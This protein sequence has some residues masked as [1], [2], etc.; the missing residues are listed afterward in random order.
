MFNIPQISTLKQEKSE[1]EFNLQQKTQFEFVVLLQHPL[2]LNQ[3]EIDCTQM[4][5][6]LFYNALNCCPSSSGLEKAQPLWSS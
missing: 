3:P 2:V 1:V 4:R 5:T 6:C